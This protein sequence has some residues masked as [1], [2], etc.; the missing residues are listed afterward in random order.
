MRKVL[1]VIMSIFL[2]GCSAQDPFRPYNQAMYKINNKIRPITIVPLTNIYTSVSPSALS[3]VL[4]NSK[5]FVKT[6][7][8][9]PYYIFQGQNPIDL[10]HRFLVDLLIG[11]A[12]TKVSNSLFAPLGNIKSSGW[13]IIVLPIYGAFTLTS[14]IAISASNQI[15]T[16]FIPK[17][18]LLIWSILCR[19]A[20]EANTTY[21]SS[22]EIAS[23]N[24]N[25]RETQTFALTD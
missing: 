10:W 16:I 4:I 6:S 3:I 24:L 5:S 23:F 18:E 17:T 11:G 14:L 2:C 22:Y 7:M 19:F 20:D 21:P 8:M 1:A 9:T 15:L 13:P 12:S 25:G